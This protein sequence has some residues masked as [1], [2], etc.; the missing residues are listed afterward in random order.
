MIPSTSVRRL[1]HA[2]AGVTVAL[3]AGAALLAPAA[4][5]SQLVD[6][7][8]TRVRLRVDASGQALLTYRA[9]GR[10]ENSFLTHRP[11]GGWCYGFYSF[12]PMRNGY[13]HPPGYAGGLR[14]PGL[15]TRYRITARGPGVTPDV[16]WQGSGFHAFDARSPE[17]VSYR[18]KIAPV[19]QDVLQ[20]D[21]LCHG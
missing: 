12:D 1:L 20:G 2:G 15:G 18:T 21:P 8:A 19:F 9:D 4:D 3:C 11:T 14:G 10:R 16:M 7:N 13:E 6:R 17:D 5:A